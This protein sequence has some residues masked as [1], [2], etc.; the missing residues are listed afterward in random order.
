MI[1]VTFDNAA[2]NIALISPVDTAADTITTQN[3]TFNVTSSPAIISNCSLI[4]DGS[5]INFISSVNNGTNGMLN[6]SLSV[7]VHTWSINC[8]DNAGGVGNSSSRTITISAVAAASSGGGGGSLAD[9]P[10]W[11]STKILTDQQF[12]VG[13]TKD[14]AVKNRIQFNV[15]SETHYVGVVG[16]TATTATI[17]ISSTPQQATLSVGGEKKFD[18]NADGYYDVYVRLNSITGTKASVTIKGI[19]EKI[20]ASTLIPTIPSTPETPST[21]EPS[22]SEVSETAGSIIWLWLVA[23]AVVIIL[24]IV[25]IVILWKG[26][27]G[28]VKYK[29]KHFSVY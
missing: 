29:S 23:I 10:Y 25:I 28:Y 13:T 26:R 9:I 12:K 2:P 1:Q 7:A 22:V 21:S 5:V 4:L 19:N 24:I 18:V 6:T 27:T 8:S 3:F 20:Q 16:L 11:T 15:N 14:L 17:E